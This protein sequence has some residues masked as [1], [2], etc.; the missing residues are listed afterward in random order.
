MS[1]RK[2]KAAVYLFTILVIL[3]LYFPLE[4]N[5]VY[6]NHDSHQ[7]ISL[8][9]R[10]YLFEDNDAPFTVSYNMYVMLLGLNGDGAHRAVL[11]AD[12]F[13]QSLANS[14]PAGRP[15]SVV[16]EEPLHVQYAMNY[17]VVH[18]DSKLLHRIE[19]VS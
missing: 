12:V 10:G 7:G 15:Y 4:K 18:A 14:F 6:A 13:Q 1:W 3:V 9:K 19:Q 17:N 8:S 5:G 2:G 11:D 16:A